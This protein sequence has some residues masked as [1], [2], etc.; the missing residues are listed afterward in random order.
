MYVALPPLFSHSLEPQNSTNFIV[1]AD[2]KNLSGGYHTATLS[3]KTNLG[4]ENVSINLS[5][6][7][8]SPI[9]DVNPNFVSTGMLFGQKSSI[10]LALTNSGDERLIINVSPD[11]SWIEIED[12]QNEIKPHSGNQLEVM[13]NGLFH[14]GRIGNISITSKNETWEIPIGVFISDKTSVI[15]SSCGIVDIAEYTGSLGVSGEKIWYEFFVPSG[16]DQLVFI[17]KDTAGYPHAYNFYLYD[18]SGTRVYDDVGSGYSTIDNPKAGTWKTV[19]EKKS[20]TISGS[21]DVKI[22]PSGSPLEITLSPAHWDAGK[23]QEDEI[24][25]KNF[26]I[27]TIGNTPIKIEDVSTNASWIEI[28]GT[29]NQTL[30]PGNTTLFTVNVSPQGLS[31]GRHGSFIMIETDHGQYISPVSM[32]VGRPNGEIMPPSLNIAPIHRNESLYFTFNIINA[33][34]SD[35]TIDNVYSTDE[36]LT[37]EELDK[38]TTSPGEMSNLMISVSHT[39]MGIYF[40]SV[41]IHT[42]AGEYQI[43]VS[44][45]VERMAPLAPVADAGLDQRVEIGEIVQFDGSDSYDLDGFIETYE[46]DFGDGTTGTGITPMHVYAANGTYIVTLTVTDNASLSD[47]DICI[48]QVGNL[49]PIAD[50]GPDQRVDVGKNVQFDGSGSYDPDGFIVNYEWDFGD[51]ANGTGVAPTHNYT[52]KENYT[53]KLTVT[54]NDGAVDNDT[55]IINVDNIPPIADAGPD[56]RVRV[57]ETVQ[58]DGSGSYDPD[59]FLVTHKWDFGD[60]KSGAGVTPAHGYTANGTYVVTLT[61]TDNAS[62][63]DA[64]TC[65]IQVSI[66]NV[67]ICASP[68]NDYNP[69]IAVKDSNAYAVWQRSS[70]IYFAQSIDGG[71]NWE[72]YGSIGKGSDPSIA[73]DHRGYIYVVWGSSGTIYISNSTDG[74]STFSTPVKIGSGY[75][76]DLAIDNNGY[77]YVVWQKETGAIKYTLVNFAKSED[78]G[79]T[80]SFAWVGTTTAEYY[81]PPKVAVSPGGNN[82]YVVWVCPPSLGEHIR[83]YFSRSTDGGIT[84]SPRENPTDFIRHGEYNPDIAAC[85]E[86]EVY[87]AWRLDRY[88]NNH[89]YFIKSKNGGV[90]FSSMIRVNDGA[91]ETSDAY[92][93]SIAVDGSGGIY[94]AWV[95]NRGGDRDIYFD[96]SKDGGS[97]FGVDIRVDNATDSSYQTDPSI[98]VGTYGWIIIAWADKRN[99]NYD[100]YCAVLNTTELMCGDVNGDEVVDMSDVR[101]LLYYVGYPGQYTMYCKWAADVNCD[102]QLNMSDVIDLL[103]HVG[104]PGQY[105]LNCCGM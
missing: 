34:N 6:E 19:V 10:K 37:I 20:T 45:V 79:A 58:F 62:A 24:K 61:V 16:V 72:C 105:E 60:G 14:G 8:W 54:D 103:Y 88:H 66:D 55:C 27:T 76:P 35:L 98:A 56:Q 3:V 83:V 91:Y 86:N 39:K 23:L 30:S 92:L 36:W 46:W 96:K 47:T 13:L 38:N 49:L 67:P 64:D 63:K 12:L 32:E 51:G 53:V 77:L 26:T 97:S 22:Y 71:K 17:N 59:G 52:I 5:V 1:F 99:G 100:I 73:V 82:V 28:T 90:S 4:T 7:P 89:V 43:L 80:W 70:D 74:G 75:Y 94:S 31:T 101:A 2:A 81:S 21:Y 9:I 85:G 65:I 93:P 42:N 15:E 69:S 11:S 84:F 25:S 40:G 87:I 102:K 50:A 104:Y 95:D 44:M 18:P 29:F 57:G 41:H 33:G 78:Q 68:E 48:I